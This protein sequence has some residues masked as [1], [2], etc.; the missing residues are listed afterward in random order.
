M[1]RFEYAATPSLHLADRDRR[2]SCLPL[3]RVWT[4]CTPLTPHSATQKLSL[5][6]F[7]A[8]HLKTSSRM[9]FRL[10]LQPYQHVFSLPADFGVSVAASV[11]PTSVFLSLLGH[12]TRRDGRV[13]RGYHPPLGNNTSLGIFFS[14]ACHCSGMGRWVEGLGLGRYIAAGEPGKSNH[15][16]FSQPASP[17]SPLTFQRHP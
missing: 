5:E 14:L 8:W 10:F 3:G 7:P 16:D 17:A 1:L 6:V 12:L 2:F 4:H 11:G 15:L 13:P 9:E